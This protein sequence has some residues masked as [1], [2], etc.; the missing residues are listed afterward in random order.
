M[1]M[2]IS[3][4][5]Q[6]KA[7]KSTR[8]KKCKCGQYPFMFSGRQG[9]TRKVVYSVCCINVDCKCQPSTENCDDKQKAIDQWNTG[10]V[11]D[12]LLLVDRK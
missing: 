5:P 6:K 4:Q 11:S 2:N 7:K 9:L 8:F 1:S 3:D 10:M 12:S